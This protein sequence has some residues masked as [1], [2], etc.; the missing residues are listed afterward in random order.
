MNNA[1]LSKGHVFA[2]I[3]ITISK[4]IPCA[5]PQDPLNTLAHFL[6]TGTSYGII[7]LILQLEIQTQKNYITYP[8]HITSQW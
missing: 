4:Y 1:A 5:L 7:S 3:V 2:I 8:H 6:I